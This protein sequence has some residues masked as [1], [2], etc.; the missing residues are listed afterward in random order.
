MPATQNTAKVEVEVPE[1][2]TATPT[3]EVP[4]L[5][6][7]AEQTN[8]TAG[9]RFPKQAAEEVVSPIVLA[10]LVGCRPQMVYNY[11]RAG[12]LDHKI[13]DDTQKIVIPLDKA[14]AWATAYLTR[15]GEKLVQIKAELEAK[16]D[17]ATPVT[18]AE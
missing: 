8:T 15:K 9:T 14:Q 3:I 6:E 16:A 10:E 12:K 17:V 11:I 5:A 4:T 2:A 13:T 18:E 1:Q 7:L